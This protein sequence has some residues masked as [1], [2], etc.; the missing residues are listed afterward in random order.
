M[1]KT[2]RPFFR[3]SESE[4]RIMGT[5]MIV[6]PKTLSTKLIEVITGTLRERFT[7]EGRAETVKFGCQKT[8]EDGWAVPKGLEEYIDEC[9]CVEMGLQNDRELYPDDA[10]K[11][12]IER[13]ESILNVPGSTPEGYPN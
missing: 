7:L 11:A 2:D 8:I 1:E 9:K 3:F 12:L 4:M 10:V 6:P 5:A 13:F